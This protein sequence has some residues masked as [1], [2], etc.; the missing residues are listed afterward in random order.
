MLP[1]SFRAHNITNSS[2]FIFRRQSNFRLCE[3]LSPT[4][5]MHLI[6]IIISLSFFL[7][8]GQNDEIFFP[9][10]KSVPVQL[11]PNSRTIK[12]TSNVAFVHWFSFS[13]FFLFCR[14]FLSVRKSERERDFYFQFRCHMHNISQTLKLNCALCSSSDCVTLAWT[15]IPM[16]EWFRNNKWI[17]H[18]HSLDRQ[19]RHNTIHLHNAYM[20]KGEK[21]KKKIIYNLTKYK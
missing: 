17:F 4:N 9:R 21:E 11:C 14:L 15:F 18:S 2:L 12:Q 7:S 13:W 19:R 20:Q 6:T 3:S 1:I 10:Y 8:F 16:N 5:F